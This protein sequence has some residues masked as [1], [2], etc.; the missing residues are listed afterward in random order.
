MPNWCYNRVEIHSEKEGAIRR[1]KDFVEDGDNPFSLNKIMP[2]PNA[3]AASLEPNPNHPPELEI[4][5][6][7]DWYHWRN[8]VWGVKWDTSEPNGED[9]RYAGLEPC[10]MNTY[11]TYLLYNFDTPW[12]PPTGI[13]KYL[14]V[15]G[16]IALTGD[17]DATI[18]WYYHEWGMGAEGYLLLQGMNATP[19]QWLT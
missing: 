14:V 5:T 7:D 1:F 10:S 2:M 4:P 16:L 11:E 3:V 17:P 9:G 8:E 6:S 18:K 19:T 15:G 12:G 13:Y